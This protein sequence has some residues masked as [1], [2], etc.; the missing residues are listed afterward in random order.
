MEREVCLAEVSEV[1]LSE[2]RLWMLGKM[3]LIKMRM[4]E[5]TWVHEVSA[6]SEL[7]VLCEVRVLSL[8]EVSVLSLSEVSVLSLSEVRVIE[9]RVLMFLN[10][11]Y[12][13]VRWV[14]LHRIPLTYFT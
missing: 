8:S 9:V 11:V 7:S 5:V 6:L 10:T 14:R 2:V 3:L 1:S 4:C 13:R 12:R